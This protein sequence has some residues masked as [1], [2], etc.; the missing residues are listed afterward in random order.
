VLSQKRGFCDRH[1]SPAINGRAGVQNSCPKSTS[2]NLRPHWVVQRRGD[3]AALDC[4][5]RRAALTTFGR[6]SCG[7]HCHARLG[8]SLRADPRPVV[9]A[10]GRTRASE[11]VRA[12][13]LAGATSLVL[14]SW[15]TSDRLFSRSHGASVFAHLLTG[16]WFGVA[17]GTQASGRNAASE[18]PTDLDDQQGPS[19]T[20][21]WVTHAGC[22]RPRPP[23]GS[24]ACRRPCA[25][26][27]RRV[28][29]LESEP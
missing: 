10:A 27:P 9:S 15:P 11:W 29:F 20:P 21:C 2:H 28:P 4:T 25:A 1:W 3:G 22:R 16:A 17:G 8:T 5:S 19:G 24:W 7:W 12:A 23:E 14:R 13:R 26:L 6:G 18:L